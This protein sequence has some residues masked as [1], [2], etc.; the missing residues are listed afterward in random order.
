MGAIQSIE[1]KIGATI[2]KATNL[3][4]A[5][6]LG[7]KFEI[8]AEKAL[9]GPID[10]IGSLQI[11]FPGL[12]ETTTTKFTVTSAGYLDSSMNVSDFKTK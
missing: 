1:T 10:A 7:K 3:K 11:V 9:G 8:D 4:P 12:S 5:V 2:A 6:K